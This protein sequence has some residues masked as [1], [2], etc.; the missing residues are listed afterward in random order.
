M[1]WLEDGE[2]LLLISGSNRSDA[3]TFHFADAL[4]RDTYQ[5]KRDSQELK[6]SGLEADCLSRL[7][8]T[9]AVMWSSSAL[10][11]IAGPTASVMNKVS[12]GCISLSLRAD[13]LSFRGPV[14]A[15]PFSAAPLSLS[16]PEVPSFLKRKAIPSDQRIKPQP[17]LQLSSRSSDRLLST[18]AG[19]QVIRA[20]LEKKY[21]VPPR[22]LTKVLQAPMQ[23]TIHPEKTGPYRAGLQVVL[24]LKP[25]QQKEVEQTLTTLSSLLRERGLISASVDQNSAGKAESGKDDT[26]KIN[27]NKDKLGQ[28]LVWMNGD[29]MMGGWSVS[30]AEKSLILQL[31]LGQ[32][33]LPL[34]RRFPDPSSV[35][36]RLTMSPS[37]L[38]SLGW[39]GPGWPELVRKA[40]SLD[41]QVVPMNGQ[42]PSS[43]WDWVEGELSLR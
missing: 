20:Q 13:I 23:L 39:L 31:S 17:L 34:S 3:S 37:Q 6:P 40:T 25:S 2:P 28:H 16:S 4:H 26:K 9:T 43:H 36:L 14:A 15:R 24:Q 21:G 8:T 5:K 33:P 35:D 27:S 18:L 32:S 11:S 1:A 38:T 30:R 19:R 42:A 12:H 7:N 22:L 41:L 10:V 29:Q